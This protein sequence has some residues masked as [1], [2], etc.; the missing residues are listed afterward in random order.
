[1]KSGNRNFLEPSGP[2]WACNRTALPLFTTVLHKD[3]KKKRLFLYREVNWLVLCNWGAICLLWGTIWILYVIQ[4]EFRLLKLDPVFCIHG[5]HGFQCENCKYLTFVNRN[6][7]FKNLTGSSENSE[8]KRLNRIGVKYDRE[9]CLYSNLHKKHKTFTF[10]G[11][12][13]VILFL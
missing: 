5:W 11:L 8:K 9:I 7:F 10:I 12:C 1:M 4:V 2:Q 13:L 6:I 3:L